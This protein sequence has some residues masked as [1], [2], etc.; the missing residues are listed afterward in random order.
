[1]PGKEWYQKLINEKHWKNIMLLF[2]CN[3]KVTATIMLV[4]VMM[5]SPVMLLTLTLLLWNTNQTRLCNL[6]LTN[7]S[8]QHSI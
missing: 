7:R 8:L 5:V 2:F 6:F 3:L 1:M 4:P